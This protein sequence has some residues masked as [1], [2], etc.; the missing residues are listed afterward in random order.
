MPQQ[1]PGMPKLASVHT[2]KLKWFAQCKILNEYLLLV[3]IT[4]SML[5]GKLQ[6][7]RC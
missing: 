7:L 3:D 2:G 1:H 6:W 5:T 4:A